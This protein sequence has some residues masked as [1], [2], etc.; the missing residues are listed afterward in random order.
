[1]SSLP[2]F[3]R[4]RQISISLKLEWSYWRYPVFFSLRSKFYQD[5][6]RDVYD[7][8]LGRE[9]NDAGSK[10]YTNLVPRVPLP[11]SFEKVLLW[12]RTR[13]EPR[14]EARFVPLLFLYSQSLGRKKKNWSPEIQR[15]SQLR[16]RVTFVSERKL[17]NPAKFWCV[18][19]V[20][21]LVTSIFWLVLVYLGLGAGAGREGVGVVQ[22]F[23]WR[24]LGQSMLLSQMHKITWVIFS[25]I[26]R[27]IRIFFPFRS[28]L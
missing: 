2:W 23:R 22:T 5:L 1:M 21:G 12:R 6:R 14:S 17:S 28:F 16:W 13:K 10:L 18:S 11:F 20:T 19:A 15:S 25:D 26:V 3:K 8:R 4:S 27:F 7:K 24:S 9:K